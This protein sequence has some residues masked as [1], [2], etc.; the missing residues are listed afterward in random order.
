VAVGSLAT[1][2]FNATHWPPAG[3][4]FANLYKQA[5]AEVDKTKRREIIHAMQLEEYNTGGN[6]IAFFRNFVD[7]YSTKVSGFRASRG[8]LQ[9]DWYGHG[10]RTIWFNS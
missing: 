1:S 5:V 8:T 7:A 9:L 10:Y 4:D 3:S 2:P 6:I